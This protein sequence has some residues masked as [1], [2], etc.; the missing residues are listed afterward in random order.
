MCHT[1]SATC[2]PWRQLGSCPTPA[3]IPLNMSP[4]GSLCSPRGHTP[5]TTFSPSDPCDVSASTAAICLGPTCGV[6][7]AVCAINPLRG[8][9][10]RQATSVFS[11]QIMTHKHARRPTIITTHKHGGSCQVCGAAHRRRFHS[12]EKQFGDMREVGGV[13]LG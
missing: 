12:R 5:R 4:C 6:L 1:H 11:V 13:C 8:R 7:T 9:A 10:Y 2:L 3:R